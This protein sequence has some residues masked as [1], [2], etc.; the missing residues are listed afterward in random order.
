MAVLS[1][2]TVT[3]RKNSLRKC[4][5]AS[6]RELASLKADLRRTR[7]KL[8]VQKTLGRDVQEEEAQ[9]RVWEELVRDCQKE[10]DELA[11]AAKQREQAEGE[12][13]VIRAEVDNIERILHSIADERERL[14]VELREQPRVR[15]LEN[16]GQTGDSAGGSKP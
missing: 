14:R 7:G 16:S 9:I 11:L 8:K 10:A 4:A 2:Q 13:M 5:S 12:Y 6:C 3:S 15:I 1:P